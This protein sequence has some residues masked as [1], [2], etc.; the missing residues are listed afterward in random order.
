MEKFR[1]KYRIESARLKN[2]DYSSNGMYFITICTGNR[3][4]FFGEI[5]NDEMFLNDVGKIANQCWS[6]IPEHFQNVE[7]GEFVIMPNHVHGIII[8]DKPGAIVETLHATSLPTPPKPPGQSKSRPAIVHKNELMAEIS[9]KPN[10]VSAIIRS[11]KS[12]VTRLSKPLCEKFEWQTR[13][14][15]HIIRT[16]DDFIRISNYIVNNPANWKEDKFFN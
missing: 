1:S 12:A 13:F 2:W 5:V 16:N 15:D 9:P 11:F 8:I 14:H 4:H 7:L 3:E 10:S 6:E